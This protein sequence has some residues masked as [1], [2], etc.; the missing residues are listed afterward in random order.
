MQVSCKFSLLGNEHKAI[1]LVSGNGD[2]NGGLPPEIIVDFGA[3]SVAGSTAADDPKIPALGGS[4]LARKKI[5]VDAAPTN[6]EN[7]CSLS[8]ADAPHVVLYR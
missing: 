2:T 4:D 6:S 7:I 8:T 1:D 3:F 5:P